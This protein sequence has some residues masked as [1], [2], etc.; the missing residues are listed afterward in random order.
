MLSFGAVEEVDAAGSKVSGRSIASLASQKSIVWSQT[1]EKMSDWANATVT[2]MELPLV[3]GG[4]FK[5]Y[6]PGEN[7]K[8]NSGNAGN[9]N[10]KRGAPDIDGDSSDSVMNIVV[11]VLAFN[12]YYEVPYG[13][14]SIV[15]D[16]SG[17]KFNVKSAS[18]P[19]CSPENSLVVNLNIET[20]GSE[21]DADAV[22]KATIIEEVLE[23]KDEE[24]QEDE[25]GEGRL[26]EGNHGVGKPDRESRK[27]KAPKGKRL[28]VPAG[29]EFDIEL[30]L[31]TL[32]VKDE[33]EANCEVVVDTNADKM[34][35]AFLFP[36]FNETLLYDPVVGFVS[37]SSP[38]SEDDDS[39]S[40][41]NSSQDSSDGD[42]EDVSAANHLLDA[43][44]ITTILGAALLIGA[45]FV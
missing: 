13:N 28:K 29:G 1:T 34:N 43:T 20:K 24:P 22:S 31:P 26:E 11:E 9:K 27:K 21:E 4:S 19:F 35:I 18:W 2:R 42:D 40:P 41:E 12:D 17:I 45:S 10:G 5:S 15:M 25:D 6:C 8:G 30:D 7:T 39:P 14:H 36:A 32:V 16:R 37:E 23:V 33:T 3:F 44:L 38:S